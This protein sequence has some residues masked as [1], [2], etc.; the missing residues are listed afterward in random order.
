[1]LS[2][3]PVSTLEAPYKFPPSTT[4]MR[5]LL[6]SPTSAFPPWHFPT[7]GHQTPSGQRAIPHWCPTRISSATYAA[8][9][10]GSSVCTLVGGPVPKELQEVWPIDTVA[11]PWGCKP[12]QLLQ[13]LLQLIHQG[14]QAQSNGWQRASTSVFVRLW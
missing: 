1:M 2:P 11:H 14:P 13:S 3:F 6:D 12:P 4:Y 8:G 9:T 7:L 10:M 5:V